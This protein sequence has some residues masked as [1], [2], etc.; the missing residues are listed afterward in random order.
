MILQNKQLSSDI[1]LRI[2]P[3]QHFFRN[4]IRQRSVGPRYS[5]SIPGHVE[6]LRSIVSP[7]LPNNSATSFF[8]L[9]IRVTVSIGKLF[10]TSSP[11]FGTTHTHDSVS[12]KNEL[13]PLGFQ[14]DRVSHRHSPVV[15]N[16]ASLESSDVVPGLPGMSN[17]TRTHI[18]LT[19]G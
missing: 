8:V 3:T 13:T 15:A 10:P 1:F 6:E 4:H 14:V 2:N 18:S 9:T 12:M 11:T 5:V 19:S 17:R 16:D 7:K